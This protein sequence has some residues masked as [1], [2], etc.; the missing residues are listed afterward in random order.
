MSY[1]ND[2]ENWT[3]HGYTESGENVCV[4]NED[5]EYILFHSPHNGIGIKR[6]ADLSSWADWGNLITLGQTEWDWA[7]GRITAGAAINLKDTEG[8]GMYLLF[9]HGSGPKTEKEGFKILM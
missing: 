3:F 5:N 9:F 2:L 6:S 8:I 7:K 4:L 1:S